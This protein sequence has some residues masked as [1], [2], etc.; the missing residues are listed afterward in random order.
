MSTIRYAASQRWIHWTVAGLVAAAYALAEF[1]AA[2]R[3]AA[4]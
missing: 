2:R 3:S 4:R 1:R